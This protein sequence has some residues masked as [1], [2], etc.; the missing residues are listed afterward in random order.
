MLTLR[1]VGKVSGRRAY[2]RRTSL[3]ARH[4]ENKAGYWNAEYDCASLVLPSMENM[5]PAVGPN[6]NP[7][8]KAIPIAACKQQNETSVKIQQMIHRHSR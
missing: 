6:R 2:T 8:E 7:S 1:L 5:A 3:A 4:S